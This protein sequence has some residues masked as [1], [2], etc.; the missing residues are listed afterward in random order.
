MDELKQKYQFLR[1]RNDILT[2]DDKWNLENLKDGLR[3]FFDLKGKYP[4]VKE[5]DQFEYLPTSRTIQRSFGGMP[6]LRKNLSL[7]GPLHFGSG[8][9]RSRIAREA[10]LRARTYEK[11]FYRY[12]IKK[13]PEVRVHE[14]KIIRPGDTA[15]DFFIYTSDT[16]GIVIDLFYAMDVHSLGGVVSIKTKKYIGVKCPVYFVLVGNDQINQEI[17]N[18]KIAN[19]K[20]S[21]PTHIHVLTEMEFKKSLITL[22]Q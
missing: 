19:R 9:N 16:K 22:I 10:D 7:T 18:N 6:L 21:L 4:T 12:L 13:I 20:E 15:A 3:Y 8:D 2:R 11:E 5:V 17:I 14:H 1:K